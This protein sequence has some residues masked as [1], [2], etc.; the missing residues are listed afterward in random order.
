MAPRESI[1]EVIG[2]VS[3]A[4]REGVSRHPSGRHLAAY[5]REELSPSEMEALRDHL[6]LCPECSELLLDLSGF[7]QLGT[8]AEAQL[9][10]GR[11]PAVWRA[12]Q[13]RLEAEA[14]EPRPTP[15]WVPG[16]AVLQ[17]RGLP[18]A[19]AALLVLF[20]GIAIWQTF[21]LRQTREQLATTAEQLSR[22]EL[23]IIEVGQ[24][25]TQM[26]PQLEVPSLDLFPPGYHR[27]GEGET[28]LTI[29]PRASLY[30][31]QLHVAEV[32][33]QAE[34]QLR[35][36]TSE[37][38][39]VWTGSGLRQSPGGTFRIALPRPFLPSGRY[40]L[41]LY[42]VGESSI[43]PLVHYDLAIAFR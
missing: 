1:E 7:E 35:I 34:H 16:R 25:V 33:S 12:L 28:T 9:W 32:S 11:Q 36:L 10:T 2:T 43:Q 26:E 27:S 29:S 6:S 3:E 24:V 22:A 19:M 38:V 30:V 31:L 39:E 41:E 17:P 13:S 14:V 5:H 20:M 4:L 15:E 23:R 40:R 18:L 37:G 21:H 42:D 8:G